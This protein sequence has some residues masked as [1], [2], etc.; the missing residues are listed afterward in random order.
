MGKLSEISAEMDEQNIPEDK[1]N[2]L[3]NRVSAGMHAAE[4]KI[5]TVTASKPV[6]KEVKLNI[7]P[8]KPTDASSKKIKTGEFQDVQAMDILTKKVRLF[9]DKTHNVV[10][11]DG[12]NYVKVGVY[13]YLAS[14]LHITPSFDFA[15]ESSQNEVW[16]ICTLK[17]KAGIEITHTTMYADKDEEFLKDKPAYAVLG[18]AQTRAFVR[19][20][21]NI[22]GYL[23]E[24]AGYQ[25]VAIE[26]IEK[27]G[28]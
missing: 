16:C 22:Y 17:N 3:I 27:K 19:A 18:M 15:E 26:E 20:M 10:T 5:D 9:A 4:K 13:Q 28:K 8:I 23:M 11:L 21:K 2:S 6:K 1:R 25:S 24:Y 12:K 14:L 7:D